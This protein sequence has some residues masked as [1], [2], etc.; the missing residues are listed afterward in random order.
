MTEAASRGGKREGAGRP[1]AAHITARV[2][3]PRPVWEAIERRAQAHGC[4][5]E[6]EAAKILALYAPT[7]LF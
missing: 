7:P 2:K 5:P 3:L 1:K 6:E 4:T